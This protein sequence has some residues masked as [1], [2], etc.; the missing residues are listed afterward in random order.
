MGSSGRPTTSARSH[1]AA[2][3]EQAYRWHP[4]AVLKTQT[5]DL[6]SHPLLAKGRA[7]R[8]GGFR[9]Y[10]TRFSLAAILLRRD[11][12]GRQAWLS[13]HN[14]KDATAAVTQE[15]DHCSRPK[16]QQ[17]GAMDPNTRYSGIPFNILYEHLRARS[18]RIYSLPINAALPHTVCI[19]KTK[20]K[21]MDRTP[22]IAAAR[23]KPLGSAYVRTPSVYVV[24]L[25]TN[26]T[27]HQSA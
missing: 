23:R 13:D 2:I 17:A 27:D 7:I 14:T 4:A 24:A 19:P 26:C 20:S 3:Q 9:T 11:F 25:K 21:R 22:T 6:R 8:L 12:L 16:R 15:E 1:P 5:T 10:F 18:H